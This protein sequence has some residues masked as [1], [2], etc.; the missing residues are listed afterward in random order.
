MCFGIFNA[1]KIALFFAA[2][3]YI[4]LVFERYG[5]NNGNAI[6]LSLAS[7]VELESVISEISG[8]YVCTN[9][10]AL[11]VI[12][13]YP[14]Q[15]RSRKF[16]FDD[17]LI[18]PV[19]GSSENRQSYLELLNFSKENESDLVSQVPTGKELAQLM[20]VEL[21]CT[22][23]S[24]LIKCLVKN[25][26]PSSRDDGHLYFKTPSNFTWL[27]YKGSHGK[28]VVGYLTSPSSRIRYNN[29][30]I[31]DDEYHSNVSSERYSSNEREFLYVNLRDTLKLDTTSEFY[32]RFKPSHS[33][34]M[35]NIKIYFH[36][37]GLYYPG[38]LE[39]GTTAQVVVKG[40]IRM[41]NNKSD[42]F[43]AREREYTL[44][45]SSSEV[46]RSRDNKYLNFVPGIF[47]IY[48][49]VNY[50]NNSN[51][52][53]RYAS[54]V[55]SNTLSSRHLI[56]DIKNRNSSLPEFMIM[57]Y[58]RG[59]RF[60]ELLRRLKSIS[61]VYFYNST[62]DWQGW[63]KNALYL[64]HLSLYI[65]S[66]FSTTGR[67]LY[68]HC[69]FHGN[70]IIVHNV[71]SNTLSRIL[72][73]NMQKIVKIERIKL[74]D[75]MFVWTPKNVGD[76]NKSN[77]CTEGHEVAI[78]DIECLN[79]LVLGRL[80]LWD[81]FPFDSTPEKTDSYLKIYK[82]SKELFGYIYNI[83]EWR[84]ISSYYIGGGPEWFQQWRSVGKSN[85]KVSI[86]TFNEQFEGVMVV[87]DYLSKF[88]STNEVP[89]EPC[90]SF[91]SYLRGY[92]LLSYRIMRVGNCIR[93]NVGHF[94]KNISDFKNE[95]IS[96]SIEIPYWE[97]SRLTLILYWN[98]LATNMRTCLPPSS[99]GNSQ[100]DYSESSYRFEFSSKVKSG[101][102]VRLNTTLER[103][104][105][106]II[107]SCLDG[108]DNE[109]KEK[110]ERLYKV[111]NEVNG[112]KFTGIHGTSSLKSAFSTFIKD[113]RQNENNESYS[114]SRSLNNLKLETILA[115]NGNNGFGVS[116]KSPNL[117]RSQKIFDYEEFLLDR[118]IYNLYHQHSFSPSIVLAGI[119]YSF[120]I[121]PTLSG[122]SGKII[123][124]LEYIKRSAFISGF[125]ANND[126]KL[127]ASANSERDIS[128]AELAHSCNMFYLTY[129]VIA[130]GF[131]AKEDERCSRVLENIYSSAG[132][133]KFTR[134]KE[135]RK[136]YDE[137][138]SVL[139]AENGDQ[140]LFII[141]KNNICTYNY[142][143][144]GSNNTPNSEFIHQGFCEVLLKPL[145]NIKLVL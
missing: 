72:F 9:E 113:V 89:Q 99:K 4:F 93:R 18:D 82:K 57:E 105:C 68:L 143:D 117:V 138:K 7:L 64:F 139:F 142:F 46:W 14:A 8:Y 101:S 41:N 21:F 140:E 58:T 27:V 20:P 86:N 31:E 76:R 118:W 33:G 39:E 95:R 22:H 107:L 54:N 116:D 78:S 56:E 61:A 17:H 132:Y 127:P 43:W 128:E 111:N 42:M 114:T 38:W 133:D 137:I 71:P 51:F 144:I 85:K 102:D 90:F 48:H 1:K 141:D 11:S 45:L 98:I 59:M 83:P 65:V 123:N 40:E 122:K 96:N 88:M 19:A 10:Q 134:H 29:D 12:S 135:Y 66:T 80:F 91:G 77:P 109:F 130:I 79:S 110:Y 70:N 92:N 120:R 44:F 36:G 60:F 32:K 97:L 87:C 3:W 50:S 23:L 52:K 49:I 28:V 55:N 129:Y 121:E 104:H 53:G 73:T 6:K 108:E 124:I 5:I 2:I 103:K 15:T 75:L 69:D 100:G 125:I 145:K 34:S 24:Q 37:N 112:F 74:I 13:N 63:F 26:S 115:L 126:P 35:S 30:G 16:K 106:D 84:R 136:Y 25:F 119:R 67:Y 62:N 131:Y 94:F 81:N 47:S